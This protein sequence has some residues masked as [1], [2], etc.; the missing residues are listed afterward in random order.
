MYTRI[1]VPLDGSDVAEQ[2]LAPAEGLATQLGVPLHLLRVVDFPSSDYTYV[3]GYMTETSLMAE[4]LRSERRLA[5]E[6]LAET[7]RTIADRGPEVTTELRNGPAVR[8]LMAAMQ[9]GDMFVMAS[10]GRSGLAR[11]YLGSVA[12]QVIRSA[13]VPVLLIRA[14]SSRS[15]R[16]RTAAITAAVTTAINT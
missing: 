12:E 11:W 16:E 1:V 2:A 13:T 6:Y 9:A 3:Y 14:E 15:R 10:H 8:E 7:A 4:R 5:E